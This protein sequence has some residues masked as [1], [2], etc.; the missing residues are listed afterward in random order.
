MW[1]VVKGA[2]L[3]GIR[4]V[5][6]PLMFRAPHNPTR[7]HSFDSLRDNVSNNFGSSSQATSHLAFHQV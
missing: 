7:E 5:I 2:V 3:F 1:W 4:I 6:W